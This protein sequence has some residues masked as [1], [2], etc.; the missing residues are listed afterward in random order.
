MDAGERSSEYNFIMERFLADFPDNY[1]TNLE[2]EQEEQPIPCVN[3]TMRGRKRPPLR[4][5]RLPIK[6]MA[7][8]GIEVAKLMDEGIKKAVSTDKHWC[9]QQMIGRALKREK[10]S[11]LIAVNTPAKVNK[12]YVTPGIS[13]HNIPLIE[14]DV[15]VIKRRQNQEKYKC[16]RKLTEKAL[17]KN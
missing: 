9:L 17:E 14:F 1:D 12:V 16:R 8:Q 11:R 2:E 3:C 7:K 10:Y 5:L 6:A 4:S 15:T 13:Y